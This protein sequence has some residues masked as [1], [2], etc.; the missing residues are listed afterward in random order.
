M[1]YYVK[2]KVK[3][4]GESLKQKAKVAVFCPSVFLYRY[5]KT[6]GQ[7]MITD[8][9]FERS[10]TPFAS[11]NHWQ[12]SVTTL[13]ERLPYICIEH[14][15]HGSFC[16]KRCP[17][18]LLYRYPPNGRTKSTSI[19]HIVFSSNRRA[20]TAVKRWK[21]EYFLK[22]HFYFLTGKRLVWC[23]AITKDNN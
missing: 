6:D 7:T 10:Q 5:K 8:L 16:Q 17:S 15:L 13:F 9:E 12:N 21:G 3:K 23:I 18:V 1:L 2:R 19:I 11:T 20:F 4:R 14:H 22:S